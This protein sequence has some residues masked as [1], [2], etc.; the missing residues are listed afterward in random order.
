MS[1][2]D[3]FPHKDWRNCL[4]SVLHKSLGL[5]RM[6]ALLKNL[7]FVHAHFSFGDCLS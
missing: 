3:R 1:S 5:A 2:G 7:E 4:R 6:A